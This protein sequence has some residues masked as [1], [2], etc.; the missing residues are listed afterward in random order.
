[1][2]TSIRC[3]L[4]LA[5]ALPALPAGAIPAFARKYE[6]SCLTCHTVFP[7]LN[8][9]GEAFRRNG[10][11]FPG[12]DSD[13]VK[14]ASIALGQEAN[15]KTF[16]ST[17]WPASIPGSVPLSIGANGQAVI[18]PSKTTSAGRQDAAGGRPFSGISFQDLVAEG[19]VWA[20]AAVEDALTLWGELTFGSDGTV[21]VEHFQVLFEDL[22]GPKHAVNLVVGHGFPAVTP[23]GPHSSYVADLMLTNLPVTGIYGTSP[24]PWT[25]VDSY[26]GLELNG[27]VSGRVGWSLGLNADKFPGGVRFPTESVYGHVGV[28]LG[29]MRLDGEGATAPANALRPWAE[30]SLTPYVFAYHS[31]AWWNRAQA[32]SA[33]TAEAIYQNDVANTVGGG[34]RAQLASLE[35][36]AGHYW[37]R[38]NH[39]TDAFA[40]VTANVTFAELSYVV[41]PWL[42][43]AVRF[44]RAS[45]GPAGGSSASDVH[46]MPGVAFLV[47]PNVRFL[48]VANWEHA[49][50][51]PATAG[52]PVAWDGGAADWGK[53]VMAP[54]PS[55]R[56]SVSEL[57]SFAIFLQWAI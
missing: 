38:H 33:P 43:P 10:Y 15:K 28:K 36:D 20:G 30:T 4:A 14:Q 5:L 13:Y 23:F 12:V 44:E 17:V 29:G 25:I 2:S 50:G 22:V 55:G 45:L 57:E 49:S 51:F 26:T 52:G 6:T 53:L 54:P 18:V 27:V 1:M 16:P 11:R 34:V 8:P 32:P 7:K 3:A 39:G 56:S 24:D 19:H 37:S 46:L 31:N 40:K 35:L 21:D 9:F 41:Y 42:V 47:R 48:A